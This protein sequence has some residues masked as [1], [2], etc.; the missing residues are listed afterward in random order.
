MFL[1]WWYIRYSSWLTWQNTIIMNKLF[2]ERL[3]PLRKKLD[4]NR[5]SVRFS[6]KEHRM[7]NGRKLL[8]YVPSKKQSIE[9]ERQFLEN[10]YWKQ[11]HH[12][13]SISLGETSPMWPRQSEERI[14]LESESALWNFWLLKKELGHTL[15]SHG[16][17]LCLFSES[18]LLFIEI[19][20]C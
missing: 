8:R 11:R 13:E 16:S 19:K 20:H 12:R 5:Q 7:C 17:A 3:R 14:H 4:I 18:A 10:C 15:R 9:E 1:I 2:S 6:S